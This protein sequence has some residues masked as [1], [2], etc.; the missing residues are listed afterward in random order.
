MSEPVDEAGRKILIHRETRCGVCLQPVIL[1]EGA[2]CHA[3]LEDASGLKIPHVCDPRAVVSWG[4]HQRRA[5]RKLFGQALKARGH[6]P[7]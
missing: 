5:M 7:R 2:G 6:E 3:L 1:S 4:I